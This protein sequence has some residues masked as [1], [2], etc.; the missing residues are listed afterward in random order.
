MAYAYISIWGALLFLFAFFLA[1]KI[2]SF[3]PKWVL[4]NIRH[5]RW[6]AGITA[7]IITII[8]VAHKLNT[9]ALDPQVYA[10]FVSLFS[11]LALFANPPKKPSE[12]EINRLKKQ[13]AILLEKNQSLS[14]SLQEVA[15]NLSRSTNDA[16]E[17]GVAALGLGNY[18]EALKHLQKA[19]NENKLILEKQ[20]EI[21]FYEGNALWE[22]G[23][24]EE[25]LQAY[26]KAIALKPDSHEA[27]YNKGVALRKLGKNEEALQ[28]YDEEIAFKPDLHEAWYNK[29]N[30]LAELGREEETLQAYDKAIA[31]KPDHQD[32]WCNKGNSLAEL[33][34]EEEALQAYDKAIA[35]K[36]DDYEA[37]YNK[38][39]ALKLFGKED[40]AQKASLKA[41]ELK[42]S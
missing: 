17:L 39:V 24:Y 7:A 8:G 18:K 4:R 16:F 42:K 3:L 15:V 19:E 29:G 13:V 22:L 41:E 26:N 10:F 9:P 1:R 11:I 14:I 6:A 36:P 25:A 5:I 21:F 23:K 28:A 37:W 12:E 31:L 27:W 20:T 2:N 35:L 34:R 38:G 33:G 30:F 32:A 40:E